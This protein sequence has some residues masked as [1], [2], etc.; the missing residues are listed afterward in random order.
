MGEPTP[1][2]ETKGYSSMSTI[3]PPPVLPSIDGMAEPDRTECYI[4]VA[5]RAEEAER[6]EDMVA[7]MQKVTTLLPDGNALSSQVKDED[8]NR[9]QDNRNLISVGY[10]NMIAARRA[11]H[12]NIQTGND[13][14]APGNASDL[15]QKYKDTI[16]KEID[17][18]I[19]MVVET[20]AED[21]RPEY[22]QKHETY[23]TKA[24]E[25]Y[26]AAKLAS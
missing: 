12:R 21:P 4:Y 14:A 20:T 3:K 1:A 2:A 15:V 19:D 25:A 24:T 17:A 10:K 22:Q 16:A 9:G 5:K 11:A 26:K 8:S 23:K 6:Y 18:I 7:Y 13:P